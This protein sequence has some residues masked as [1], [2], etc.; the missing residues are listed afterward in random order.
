MEFSKYGM[1]SHPTDGVKKLTD[2]KGE[3]SIIGHLPEVIFVI[4]SNKSFY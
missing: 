4:L 2:S 1:D 3:I